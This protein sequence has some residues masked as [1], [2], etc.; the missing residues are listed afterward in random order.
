MNIIQLGR[1]GVFDWRAMSNWRFWFRREWLAP[2]SLPSF[3]PAHFLRLQ[4]LV[5]CRPR[6]NRCPSWSDVYLSQ[7]A[8]HCLLLEMPDLFSYLESRIVRWMEPAAQW[9]HEFVR[10][11]VALFVN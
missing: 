10:A 4:A 6:H 8:S 11:P 1:N 2:E 3:R 5:L 7:R 9:L